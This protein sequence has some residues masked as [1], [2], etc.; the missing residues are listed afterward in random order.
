MK[1]RITH[2]TITPTEA[3]IYYTIDQVIETSCTIALTDTPLTEE[4]VKAKIIE[5]I[6]IIQEARRRAG[7]LGTLR[8][9]DYTWLDL[10]DGDV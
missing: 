3:R 2:C 5:N 1:V 9:N 8:T 6:K 10:G 7:Y 4:E